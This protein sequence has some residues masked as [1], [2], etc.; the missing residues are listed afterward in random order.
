VDFKVVFQETFL[1]DLEKIVRQIAAE[2]VPAAAK[3]GNLI[4]SLG[5]SLAFFPQRH[6]RVKQRPELR[7][8]IV[9][10]HYKVFYRVRPD[11]HIVEILR[12]WD[13]RQGVEPVIP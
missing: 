12:C 9:A 8:Y 4:V 5:E 2:N 6:P 1:E 13:G 3:L 7:R 11:I 10:R